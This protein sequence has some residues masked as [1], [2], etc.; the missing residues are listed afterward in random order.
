MVVTRLYA[1][2]CVENV[3]ELLSSI[4]Q[5]S[6]PMPS[7]A[8]GENL[9]GRSALVCAKSSP[10]ARYAKR[11]PRLMEFSTGGSD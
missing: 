9:F 4:F 1:S 11:K 6:M 10:P 8:G 3:G 7:L 5:S 2:L